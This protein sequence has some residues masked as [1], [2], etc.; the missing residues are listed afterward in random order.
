M[1]KGVL[2]ALPDGSMYGTRGREAPAFVLY[3]P[4]P[5]RNFTHFSKSIRSCLSCLYSHAIS[6]VRTPDTSDTGVDTVDRF[7]DSLQL[8]S[9]GVAQ[10]LSLLQDLDWLH[11]PNANGLFAA[12]DVVAD[13][14][15]VFRRTGRYGELDLGVCGGELGKLRLDEAAE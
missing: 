4:S 12:I 15:G 5:F 2:F 13:N 1:L 6:V 11:I 14:D 10:K 7:V 8:L 3:T 9:V